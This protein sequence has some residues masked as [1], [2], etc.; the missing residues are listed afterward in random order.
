M[1]KV[2]TAQ[3]KT[4]KKVVKKEDIAVISLSNRMTGIEV[5]TATIADDVKHH[6]ESIDKLSEISAGIKEML[7]AQ[8]NRIQTQENSST[9]LYDLA[10]KRREEYLANA[11]KVNTKFETL[12]KELHGVLEK[13]SEERRTDTASLVESFRRELSQNSKELETSVGRVEKEVQK[14]V[15]EEREN[16]RLRKEEAN[17]THKDLDK[18]I[19]VLERSKWIGMGILLVIVT[20]FKFINLSSIMLLLQHIH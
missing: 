20:L 10:E 17:S 16:S 7:A 3:Q 13:V 4:R 9:L 5:T 12:A 2:V 6:Q 18:R 15:M 14:F 19:K 1:V 11:E 8:E